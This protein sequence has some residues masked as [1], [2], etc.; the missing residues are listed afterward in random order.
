VLLLPLWPLPTHQHIYQSLWPLL[1]GMD[2]LLLPAGTGETT[3]Y[4]HW[5]T[6]ASQPGPQ[7]WSISWEIALCQL[8]TVVGMPVLA[9]GEGAEKWNVALGGT[10]Q[11]QAPMPHMAPSPPDA[12]ERQIVRV[13][14]KST[15]ATCIQQGK[16]SEGEDQQP[17]TL[18]VMPSQRVEKLAPGLRSCAHSTAWGMVAFERRDPAFGLGMLA[19]A[20]WGLE[21]EESSAL[22]EAFVQASRSFALARQQ[23]CDW[24]SSRDAICASISEQVAQEQPLLPVPPSFSQ[25]NGSHT[26]SVSSELSPVR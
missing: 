17:W 8:A 21:Q 19:R 23:P 13:R 3:W 12:W 22:F 10:L 25:G 14:A 9:I 6:R 20:D 2:G 7:T 11:K 4:E 26:E 15:L 1:H 16:L 18:P 24:E 5:K